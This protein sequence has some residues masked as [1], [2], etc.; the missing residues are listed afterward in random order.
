MNR[1]AMA[2]ISA[3]STFELWD[4]QIVNQDEAWEALDQVK[5]I[6]ADCSDEEKKILAETALEAAE[7]FRQMNG[8]GTEKFCDD[9]MARFDSVRK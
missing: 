4:E 1:L 6:L 3:A 9:F 8:K 2:V 5:Y 7:L